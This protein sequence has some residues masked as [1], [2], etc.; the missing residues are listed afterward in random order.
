M[1]VVSFRNISLPAAFPLVEDLELDKLLGNR[2]QILECICAW[3]ELHT[4]S[5]GIYGLDSELAYFP[6]NCPFPCLRTLDISKDK[7]L[8][9]GHLLQHKNLYKSLS[10]LSFESI[11][12]K[13]VETCINFIGALGSSLETLELEFDRQ[14]SPIPVLYSLD[15]CLRHT[16][17]SPHF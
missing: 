15:L 5:L 9:L 7:N 8:I 13:E 2:I 14:G 16:R 17:S 1:D 10:A 3:P 11:T 4:L 12:Y 6:S